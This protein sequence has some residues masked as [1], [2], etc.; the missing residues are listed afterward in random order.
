MQTIT[1][2]AGVPGATLRHESDQ[3][4]DAHQKMQQFL[5][6][7]TI[8]TRRLVLLRNLATNQP[9]PTCAE[10]S[11]QVVRILMALLSWFNT[12]VVL[13]FCLALAAACFGNASASDSEAQSHIEGRI[14]SGPYSPL[15]SKEPHVAGI[16]EDQS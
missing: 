3:Q 4:A 2:I 9:I 15:P 8:A 16:S 5:Y 11:Q 6:P 12:M 13:I 14:R 7:K 10:A 1:L